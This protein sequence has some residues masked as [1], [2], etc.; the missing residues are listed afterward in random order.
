MKKKQFFSIYPLILMGIFFVFT[1]SC[2]KKDDNE[3]SLDNLTNGKT[4]AVFNEGVTYNTIIDQ[5]GNVYKTVTIGTQTWMAENLRTTSYNDGTPIPNVISN[6]KW[7]DLTTGAFCNYNNTNNID[8]IATYGR[9]YNWFAV[10]T[11]KLAPLGWHVPTDNEWAILINYLGGEDIAGSKLKETGISHWQSPNV[12]ANNESGFTA[13][14]GGYRSAVDGV[15]DKL[16]YFGSWWSTSENLFNDAG[17]RFVPN[18][19]SSIWRFYLS[20]TMGNSI[21]CVKDYDDNNRGDNLEIPVITTT[22]VTSISQTTAI[23]GGYITSDGGTSITERGVCWSTMQT[24]TLLDNKTQDGTG[25]GDFTSNI[26][27]LSPNTK[28]YIRAYATNSNGTGYG[29]TISFITQQDVNGSFKDSRDGKVYQTVS[30]GNQVW[31]SENLNYE[32]TSGSWVYDDD[33]DKAEIYGRLYNWETANNVCPSG[34]HLPSDEEWRELKDYLGGL[35][36]AG[37]KLKATG[38]NYWNTPNEGATNESGFNAL[39][40]GWHLFNGSYD[41]MGQWGLWWS[42]T[43]TGTNNAYCWYLTSTSD[44]IFYINYRKEHAFSVRCVKD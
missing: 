6:D 40:G 7:I 11:G 3:L 20:K 28:Y 36:I 41:K 4:T 23:S 1:I 5:E 27:N 26:T 21:R 35:G 2:E 32:T 42:D 25:V 10:N 43:E 37:G 13:L 12:G 38:T 8:S 16:G 34:W 14:P 33:A 31:M 22:K 17:R 30:I 19:E 24:P 15:F 39:P 29:S 18:Y 44:E 9:L